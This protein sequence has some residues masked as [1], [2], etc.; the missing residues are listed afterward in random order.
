MEGPLRTGA[1]VAGESVGASD[2]E[3]DGAP[4]GDSRTVSMMKRLIIL[5]KDWNLWKERLIQMVH[6]RGEIRRL[7]EVGAV[8]VDGQVPRGEF[9]GCGE[10]IKHKKRATSDGASEASA[11]EDLVC[12]PYSSVV[13]LPASSITSVIFAAPCRPCHRSKRSAGHTS[14]TSFENIFAR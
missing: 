6:P 9:K 12:C 8:D 1:G 5:R 4:A 3:E 2:G 11:G 7:Q 13:M 10:G 14:G